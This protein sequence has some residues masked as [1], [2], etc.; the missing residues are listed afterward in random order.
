[1]S[2]PDRAPLGVSVSWRGCSYQLHGSES[3]G[4]WIVRHE[5]A[6]GLTYIADST[7]RAA[8]E[9]AAKLLESNSALNS[10]F[11]GVSASVR[12]GDRL[13]DRSPNNASRGEHERKVTM[14]GTKTR[15][16][17]R[18]GAKKGSTAAKAS[19]AKTTAAKS[20]GSA[21]TKR[22]GAVAKI[23]ANVEKIAKALKGGATMKSQK[24]AYGVSDDGPIRK[25]LAVAGYDS[26]GAALSVEKFN[27]GNAAGKKRVV[28][29]RQGGTAWYI[30][31]IATGLSESELRAIVADAGG[32]T[33]RVYRNTEKPAKAAAG[34]R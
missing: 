28:K 21:A 2:N 8:I 9:T 23:N 20:N 7:A 3:A 18:S 25:A 32:P 15:V 5:G 26:K 27:A 30:L 1:M 29:E 13:P 10:F 34:G 31:E 6:G 24:E 33:G 17:V 22:T 14:A 4:Y 19:S 16:V 12:K 11:F